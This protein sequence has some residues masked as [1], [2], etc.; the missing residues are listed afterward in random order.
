[1]LTEMTMRQFALFGLVADSD[2]DKFPD[3]TEISSTLGLG[4]PVITRAFK[5]LERH[6]LVVRHV[7]IGDRRKVIFHITDLGTETRLFMRDF[8]H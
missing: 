2:N 4:K 6:G 8:A 7:N 1:M 3:Y 5:A